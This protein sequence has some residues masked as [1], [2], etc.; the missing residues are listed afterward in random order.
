MFKLLSRYMLILLATV[1][2]AAWDAVPAH[3]VANGLD[4][5]DGAYPFATRLSMTGLPDQS[6]G[7]RDSSC[8]GALIASRWVI[9]AGHCFRNLDGQRVNHPVARRTTATIGRT[10]VTGTGGHV[11]D[12]VAVVQ[13]STTDVALAELASNV[14]DITPIQVTAETPTPGEVV[15]LAGFGLTSDQDPRSLPSRLQTGLFTVDNIGSSL[16]ETSG[17]Q[18]AL[19]TS[20]CLH[21]SG[22]PYFRES[23]NGRPTLVAVVSSG[24]SC[25]H[26]GEDYS[27][28][29]DNIGGW[30]NST[31]ATRDHPASDQEPLRALA[32]A[33]AAGLVAV[34]A[35]RKMGHL[36][37][38]KNRRSVTPGA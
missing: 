9:T 24:P 5:N 16:L 38:E 33:A 37:E 4:A 12:V 18:P 21:D 30:I 7:T 27:A 29:A 35:L 15:R 1:G 8:S 6:G 17:H 13:S 3:A 36:R 31:V 22:A 34:F 20:P 10:Q 2:V 14:T 19:D 26:R 23:G 28:R 32:V 11:L 25:P